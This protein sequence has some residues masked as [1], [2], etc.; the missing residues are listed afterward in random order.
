MPG[1]GQPTAAGPPSPSSSV[2]AHS[3]DLIELGSAGILFVLQ[4]DHALIAMYREVAAH[5]MVASR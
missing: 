5:P 1:F 2:L 3:E 4:P